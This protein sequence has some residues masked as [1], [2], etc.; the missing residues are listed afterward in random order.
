M[1]RHPP[2]ISGAHLAGPRRDLRGAVLMKMTMTED[3]RT[4][5]MLA[6]AMYIAAEMMAKRCGSTPGACLRMMADLA[7]EGLTT[8]RKV[9]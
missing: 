3:E 7:D 8:V 1:I 4:Y 9:A 5:E 6:V 2:A